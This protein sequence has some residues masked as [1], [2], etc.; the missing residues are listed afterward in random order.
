MNNNEQ[1]VTASC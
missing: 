1:Q